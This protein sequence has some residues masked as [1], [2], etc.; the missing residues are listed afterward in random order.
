[1]FA[2]QESAVTEVNDWGFHIEDEEH[3][4]S[5]F[6]FAVIVVDIVVIVVAVALAVVNSVVVIADV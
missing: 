3:S 1:M 6:A 5:R 4:V 2:K